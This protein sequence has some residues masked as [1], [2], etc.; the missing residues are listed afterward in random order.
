MNALKISEQLNWNKLLWNGNFFVFFLI[1][2]RNSTRIH[3]FIFIRSGFFGTN[4]EGK[5]REKKILLSLSCCLSSWLFFIGTFIPYQHIVQVHKNWAECF[6]V[7]LFFSFLDLYFLCWFLLI[8]GK[9]L[10]KAKR[11]RNQ[12]EN[13]RED[14]D[15]DDDEKTCTR[16]NCST[17]LFLALALSPVWFDV[18]LSITSLLTMGGTENQTKFF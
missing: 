8:S 1:Q 10:K 4:E 9:S 2:R 16:N 5:N 11:T 3:L 17:F 7:P 15:D 18:Y 14:D 13:R 6:H 12:Q